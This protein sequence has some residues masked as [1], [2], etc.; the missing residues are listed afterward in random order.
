MIKN[1]V[2]QVRLTNVAV[3][4]L[5]HKGKRYELACYKNKVLDWREGLYGLLREKD[6]DEVLQIHEVYYN[7]ATGLMAPHDAMF[8]AFEVHKL[9]DVIKTILEQGELQVSELER[10]DQ[11]EGAEKEIAQ[12]VSEKCVSRTTGKPVPV[13]VRS[14]QIILKALEEVH[15]NIKPDQSTKKQALH[16]IKALKNKLNLTRMKM[17]L[18]LTYS[19]EDASAIEA[20]LG[21][22]TEENAS[23][24]G[25]RKQLLCL[26]DPDVFRKLNKMIGQQGEERLRVEIVDA[27]VADF[28]LPEPAA[29]TQRNREDGGKEEEKVTVKPPAPVRP[30]ET[31]RKFA[32]STCPGAD[33]PNAADQRSHFKTDWHKVNVKLKV[34]SRPLLSEAEF[35]ILEPRELDYW[36]TLKNL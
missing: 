26:I 11:Y 7:V 16:A 12:I 15:F 2:N 5:R 35:Q 17:R 6:L 22:F 21:E 4:R 9:E 19:S 34:A 20:V 28:P 25:G 36:M 1:P 27:H 10:R 13:S 33:F 23:V 32:C 8:R 30:T 3:V 18:R 31:V 14:M 24:D 29:S